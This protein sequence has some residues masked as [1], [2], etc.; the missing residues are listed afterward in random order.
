MS[1]FSHAFKRVLKDAHRPTDATNAI[2]RFK[3]PVKYG[4]QGYDVTQ[5]EPD[6]RV[7]YVAKDHGDGTVDLADLGGKLVQTVIKKSE[8]TLVDDSKHAG[9]DDFNPFFPSM[10]GGTGK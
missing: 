6:S 1:R 8:L 7:M 4:H 5:R 3:D 10:S 9:Q 2:V